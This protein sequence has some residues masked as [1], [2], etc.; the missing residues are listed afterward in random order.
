VIAGMDE[1]TC[2]IIGK[3]YELVVEAGVYQAESIKVAEA[4][5]VI[6]NAQRDVN[7]AFMNELSIIFNRL[8]IDTHAVLNA[9]E[10]KWNF[11]SFRPGLVGGHCIGVD[12]YYLTY[13]ADQVGYRSQIISSSRRINDGMGK[14]V[15]EQ[16]IKKLI[17]ADIS[18]KRAKIGL[19]GFTFKENCPDTRNTL[20][21]EIVEELNE[22]GITPLIFDPVADMLEAKAAY[23]LTFS[24]YSDMMEL[25]GIIVAVNHHVFKSYSVS[26][27]SNFYKKNQTKVML[28]VKGMLNKEELEAQGFV[29]WR[30]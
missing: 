16:A 28:D 7:I 2:D 26:E 22:Y 9:A 25:D 1:E 21:V 13:K 17:F 18:I 3:I 5:K 27:W 19:F 4:A 30:L 12:P 15:V 23:D 10:T 29:Y 14:Y 8:D 11:L 24:K 20:V 6:E